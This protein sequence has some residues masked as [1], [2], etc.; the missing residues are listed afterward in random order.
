MG[1]PNLRS[2]SELICKFDD[3]KSRQKRIALAG[4]VSIVQSLGKYSTVCMEDLTREIYRVGKR[5]R[6][7]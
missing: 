4:N 2:I 1:A 7:K 5:F 6:V 3:G